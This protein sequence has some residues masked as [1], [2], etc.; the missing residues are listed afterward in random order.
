[1]GAALIL[2]PL[3]SP[4]AVHAADI[5]FYLVA[6]GEVYTQTNASA[7]VLKGSP[8]RLSVIAGLVT[9]NAAT[10]VTFRALPSGPVTSLTLQSSGTPGVEDQFSFSPKFATTSALDAA[11]PDGSYQMVIGAVHDG[12][13][14]LTLTLNGGTYPANVPYLSNFAQA[15]TVNPASGF[16][17]AWTP[18]SGGT[19]NDVILL[20]F[21][22]TT[23]NTRFK[24]P[25]PGQLG[26]LNGT[27]SSFTLPPNTLPAGL[28]LGGALTFAKVVSLDTTSY[29]GVPGYTAYY[30]QTQFA[31][32]TSS[33]TASPPHLEATLPAAGGPLQIQLTGQAGLPYAIDATTN[34]QLGP[35]LPLVTN[36]AT[37]GPFIFLDPQSGS[38]PLRFYRGRSAN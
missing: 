25:D 26:C 32:A 22:D 27:V 35:W 31:L 20:S 10:N 21:S 17:V 4:P 11:Y 36:I 12:T 6:K 28:L 34:L 14:T 37:G 38:F 13:R 24:T 15:Q 23:G 5:A 29:P 3:A 9:T 7:P 16:T 2:L 30:T 18:F 33:G 1:M 8:A 19:A